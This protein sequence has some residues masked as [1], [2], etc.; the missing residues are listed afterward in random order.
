MNHSP[1]YLA[2]AAAGVALV[3]G[4]PGQ[5]SAAPGMII[6][7]PAEAGLVQDVDYKKRRWR[8]YYRDEDGE[9]VRAPFTDVDVNGGTHVEAPFTGVHTNR[10]GTWVRAPFV[11]LFVPR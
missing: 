7:A 3:L 1:L 2:I 6:K 9:H 10:Y 5:G 8:N 11:D 4:L